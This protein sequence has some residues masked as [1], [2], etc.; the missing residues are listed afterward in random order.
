LSSCWR[1]QKEVETFSS[2]HD[3]LKPFL[4]KER[5][6]TVIFPRGEVVHRNLSTA[7]MDFPAPLS[8]L[9]TGDFSGIIEI[10]VLENKQA[11][12]VDSRE[13]GRIH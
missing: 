6:K 13:K 3:F 9:K 4:Q 8:T 5:G 7:Y 2:N 10:E 1:E 11:I 12:F